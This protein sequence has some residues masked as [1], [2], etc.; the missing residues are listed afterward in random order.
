[1]ATMWVTRRRLRVIGSPF[2]V[3]RKRLRVI[4]SR[5]RVTRKRFRV[6]A[7]PFRVTG[8]RLRV[9]PARWR[10]DP[11]SRSSHPAALELSRRRPII[12]LNGASSTVTA[13]DWTPD[14]VQL[15]PSPEPTMVR[16]LS[17]GARCGSL[18]FFNGYAIRNVAKQG[19]FPCGAFR[20]ASLC[21]ASRTENSGRSLSGASLGTTRAVASTWC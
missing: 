1:M 2:R 12:V 11:H 9:M 7:S 5:V 15:P 3:T 10:T 13:G 17:Q 21:V 16:E 19:A 20:D 6:I 14:L 8:A 18:R 4:K